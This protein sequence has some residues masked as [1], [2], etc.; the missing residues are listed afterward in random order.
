MK[1]ILWVCLLVFALMLSWT[2][3]CAED[4]YVIPTKKRNYAP[5][6]KTGQTALY[7]AHDDGDLEKG[8][9]LPTPR[10]T[11]NNNGTVTDNLTGL[12]WLKNANCANAKAIWDTAIDYAAAL[13]DGCTDCFGTVGDCG[14]SDDSSAG[15]WRLPNR[16][17]L[18]SLVDLGQYE[19]ALPSVNPFT[20]VEW[21]TGNYYWSST[22]NAGLTTMAWCVL[23]DYGSVSYDHQATSSYYV[24]PV[25]GGQ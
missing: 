2:L 12:I 14:L 22:A 15:D 8:V 11:D 18:L 23:L 20:G 16:K 7:R 24:W 3:A 17:E 19:P 6:E 13:F 25:R 10:F 21:G 9:A 1:R 4:F 5:V